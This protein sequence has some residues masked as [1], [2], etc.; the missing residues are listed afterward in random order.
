MEKESTESKL[1]EQKPISQRLREHVEMRG[2]LAK[3]DNGNPIIENGAWALML[4]AAQTIEELLTVLKQI[5]VQLEY[6][7]NICTAGEI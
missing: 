6:I 5:E 4:E 2:G 1:Q 3:D 7:N